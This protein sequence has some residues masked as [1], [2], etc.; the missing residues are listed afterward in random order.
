MK[1]VRVLLAGL[2][3]GLI[4]S[5]A[6]WFF[7]V[8]G[9]TPALGFYMT[10]DLTPNWLMPRVLISGLWGLLFLLP[11]IKRNLIKKG[12]VVSIAP[13]IFMLFFVFPVKMK[14]GVLGLKLGPTAPVF[15]ILFTM[16]WGLSAAIWLKYI[17]KR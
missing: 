3:G 9:I 7:G 6:V 11:I 15:A 1:V 2:F 4:N 14:V 10:P 5:L 12:L 8:L 13:A 16:L 17:Q